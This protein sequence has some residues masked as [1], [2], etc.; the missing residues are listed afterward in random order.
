[1]SPLLVWHDLS[2]DHGV[3]ELARAKQSALALLLSAVALACGG[4]SQLDNELRTGD[5]SSEDG[6]TSTGSSAFI[7]TWTCVDTKRVVPQNGGGSPSPVTS[8]DVVTVVESGDG[9]LH[10]TVT[11]GASMTEYVLAASGE[12]ANATSGPS[13]TIPGSNAT[14][15]F[16]GGSFGL[17]PGGGAT[18]Q[19]AI[20]T[21]A[22]SG[23]EASTETLQGTCT[24]DDA[25][26]GAPG[27]P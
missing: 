9:A 13:G 20:A 21:G 10:M 24:R 15:M 6:G 23:V 26:S 22:G 16:T 14:Y 17:S 27:S 3:L 5:A 19:L 8:I 18:L 1:M 2:R 11:D 25:P 4:R 12:T 7:G